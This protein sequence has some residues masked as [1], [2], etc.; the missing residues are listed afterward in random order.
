VETVRKRTGLTQ[1]AF[2]ERVGITGSG[3]GF[4]EA[5]HRRPSVDLLR[6]MKEEFGVD[7]EEI[8]FGHPR[9][10]TPTTRSQG[11]ARLGAALGLLIERLQPEIGRVL[12]RLDPGLKL[13]GLAQKLEEL[14]QRVGDDDDD[15][16]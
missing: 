7:P 6:R 3:L 10:T 9:A 1:V 14:A 5:G 4:I 16:G 2:G 12:D 13:E 11:S 15:E 8:L